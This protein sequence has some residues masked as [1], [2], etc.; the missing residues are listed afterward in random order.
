MSSSGEEV[1][2]LFVDS[3]ELVGHLEDLDCSVDAGA[4]RRKRIGWGNHHLESM[5]EEML[6][7]MDWERLERWI[8]QI[9]PGLHIVS[10]AN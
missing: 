3:F 4:D 8:V 1:G 7:T 2:G 10:S 9:I 6:E 5:A